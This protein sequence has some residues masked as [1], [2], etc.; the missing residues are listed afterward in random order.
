MFFFSPL[1][2]TTADVFITSTTREYDV[3]IGASPQRDAGGYFTRP[4]R[5][6]RQQNANGVENVARN[7]PSP[8]AQESS[9]KSRRAR[10]SYPPP[11]PVSAVN[12]LREKKR[13]P[14]RAGTAGRRD[15][16]HT[17]YSRNER[18]RS[19]SLACRLV[20]ARLCPPGRSRPRNNKYNDASA[21]FPESRG[22]R[23]TSGPRRR[24]LA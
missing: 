2:A 14:T 18:T 24:S 1:L 11:S 3:F 22:I 16:T 8:T 13:Y 19:E 15:V 4:P 21:R 12:L 5:A 17:P 10:A 6:E 23:F 7:K 9:G 20:R